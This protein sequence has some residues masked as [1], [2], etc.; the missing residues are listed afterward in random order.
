L[1]GYRGEQPRT[2]LFRNEGG[3]R[4]LDVSARAAIAPTTYVMG[5]T[6]GDV[7]GDGDLDLYLSGFGPGQ[8]FRNGADGTFRDVTAA[9]GVGRSGWG[10]SAAFGD[11]DGDGDLDLYVAQ[12]VD[13]RLNE[14]PPCGDAARGLRSYCHPDVFTGLPDHYYRNDGGGRFAAAEAEA[15]L[16]RDTGNGLG[17]VF[18]DLDGDGRDD[19]YVAND[20]TPAFLYRNRGGGRFEEVGMLAGVAL[21][22]LGKPEAGMG[23]AVGDADGNG[24]D[25][26]FKTHLDLQTNALYLNQGD[27]LFTEG[28]YISRLA[29]PSLYLVGFGAELLDLDHDGDLDLVVANGHIIHNVEA[30]G[31]GATYEQRNQLFANLGGGVFAEVRD[32]GPQA[33]RSSRG[34]ASGDL[35]GD[36][37]LDLVITNNDNWSE[38]YENVTAGAGGWLQVDLVAAGGNTAGVGARLEVTAAGAR[39]RRQV[40]TSA[41]YLSQSAL[42]AH[43]GLGTAASAELLVRWPDGRR[44]RYRG[45]PAGR[46]LRLFAAAP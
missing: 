37:D 9:A 24:W 5:G 28:R 14:N 17:V 43:F 7:D 2:V 26:L 1:P 19:L 21:S 46:R 12:Y 6:A 20:M 40:R 41:S 10:A 15:G 42:T 25:D 27:L 31:T 18:A 45:L 13:F 30:Y 32:G 33:V 22:D 16:G 44:V 35:D 38:V 4:F 34:L 36:G 3:G 23:V 11:P 39:Q 29:E 8:L